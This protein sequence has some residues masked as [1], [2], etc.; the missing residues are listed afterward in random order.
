[1]SQ[2][3]RL[4]LLVTGARGYVAR[5]LLQAVPRDWEISAVVRQPKVSDPF[6]VC[7]LTDLSEVRALA[8]RIPQPTVIVHAAGGSSLAQAHRGPKGDPAQSANALMVANLLDAFAGQQP[9]FIHLS[10]TSVYG[11]AGRTEAIRISEKP[12][13]VTHYARSKLAAEQL[14]IASNLAD[15]RILRVGPVF[16]QDR[17]RNVSVRARLPG[18]SRGVRLFPEPRHSLIRLET[19]VGMLLRSIT[20]PAR[21]RIISNAVE[22]QEFSQSE[23]AVMAGLQ[24]TIV[25][26]R[27]LL[28]LGYAGLR[29]FPGQRAATLRDLFWK[30]HRGIIVAAESR[31]LPLTD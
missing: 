31:E 13:P 10:S 26:P 24:R 14:L 7:D 21:G 5:A 9:R 28:G 22:A 16:S 17:L 29:L 30:F 8:K 1:M 27:A 2:P 20:E 19:L 6:T 3:Q 12:R 11:E 4:R 25:L 15:L 18:T 23:L